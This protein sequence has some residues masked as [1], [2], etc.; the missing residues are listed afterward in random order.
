M[1][2]GFLSQNKSTLAI[3]TVILLIAGAVVLNYY[4]RTK[5]RSR[6]R[7]VFQEKLRQHQ[8]ALSIQQMSSEEKETKAL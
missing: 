2:Q 3:A 5:R 7:Q 6:R 4:S 8:E 1:L